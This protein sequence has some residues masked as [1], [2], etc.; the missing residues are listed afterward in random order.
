MLMAKDIPY[1]THVRQCECEAKDIP[2]Y[3]LQFFHSV[4][5]ITIRNKKKFFSS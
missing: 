4:E 5:I 3:L 2:R 1:Q